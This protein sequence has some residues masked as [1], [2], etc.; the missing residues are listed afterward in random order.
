[1][2]REL[3]LEDCWQRWFDRRDPIAR[4]RI[5]VHYS[6][7]VKFVA[8]R[9]GAGLPNSVDAGDLVSAGVF[10]LI[11]A[12][13]RFDPARGVKFE[14]FAVPRISGAVF[15]GLRSLDWVP[16]SVRSRAREVE[17][18]FQDLE[19]KMGRG[20]TDEE[21]AVH[22]KISATEF[23]KWLASI[24]STT[25]GPLDR[26]LVAGV[27]PRALTGDV[28]DSPAALVE[29]G[30]VKRLVKVELRRL[31]EREKLVLTLYYD[32]GLTLSEIGSI[33]GVTESRVS[34][35][36]TKAVLHLRARLS[37]TGVA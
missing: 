35:I 16:R 5:I 14:T 33:L 18:A 24:A 31:P 26:A 30:E 25:V 11:D 29:E 2:R 13:E 22:L 17:N 32:E 37:A 8:G 20:P 19:G 21:L 23:Q 36:H 28:P 4:D 1:M 6:P 9:V 12:V 15:D 10:G 27:E 34:Q 7:L 3:D